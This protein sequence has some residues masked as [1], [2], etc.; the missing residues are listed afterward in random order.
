MKIIS[1]RLAALLTL[2]GVFL[3]TTGCSDNDLHATLLYDQN[4]GLEKGSKIE[5][6]GFE[7]GEVKEVSLQPRLRGRGGQLH[8][9]V[10]ID[11]GYRD[12]LY[13][14]MQ[15]VVREQEGRPYV[16]VRDTDVRRPE[17][18]MA[19]EY[20]IGTESGRGRAFLSGV[21]SSAVESTLEMLGSRE[22]G[23]LQ[24]SLEAAMAEVARELPQVE[25][26][27]RRAF[28]DLEEQWPQMEQDLEAAMAELERE[29]PE[30]ERE[31]ARAMAELEREWP[32]VER[33]L[34]RAMAELEREWPR[35]EHELENALADVERE[36][37]LILD[38]IER[39]LEAELSDE[40]WAA[41]MR[42]LSA[43]SREAEGVAAEVLRELQS[44]LKHRRRE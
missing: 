3:I 43:A 21:L 30:V 5:Y 41:L 27:L 4:Y 22:E 38:E 15:F 29:W 33:E 2:G 25:D 11:E 17:P 16:E 10:A 36:W 6:E 37:P 28:A 12:M 32:A 42:E 19:G 14:Q 44:R 18:V 20:L 1:L 7:I 40:E 13:H 9:A 35:V 31:L 34:A 24:R 26:E 8:V 23:E 39:T